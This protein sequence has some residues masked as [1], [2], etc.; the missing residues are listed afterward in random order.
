LTIAPE[1]RVGTG[2]VEALRTIPETVQVP[3]AGPF[4]CGIVTKRMI[5]TKTM[6]T[7]ANETN[8]PPSPC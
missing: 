6:K 7:I 1:I 8:P 2:L 5:A 3:L 4:C